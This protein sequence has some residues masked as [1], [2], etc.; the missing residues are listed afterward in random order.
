V[1]AVTR[2]LA[3]QFFGNEDPVGQMVHLDGRMDL[4]PQQIVGVVDDM[5]QARL[6]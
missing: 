4:P 6:D 5:R 2:P 3:R 1:I